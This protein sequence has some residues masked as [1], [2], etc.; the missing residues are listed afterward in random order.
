ME[1]SR[2]VRLYGV[3]LTALVGLMVLHAPLTVWLSTVAPSYTPLIKSWKELLMLPLAVFA[4]VLVSRAGLWRELARDWLVRLIVAYALLH[5]VVAAL[6]PRDTWAMLAGLAIDLRYVLLFVLIYIL[7]RLTPGWRRWLVYVTSAGAALVAVFA[8]VQ[9]LLPRDFL[10]HLGYS[11]ATIA[12]YLTVDENQDFVRFSS[13]LRGPNPLGAYMTIVLA[14][15]AA[16]LGYGKL[17]LR[18]R[19]VL[20]ATGLLVAA[21][22][23]ALWVSHSRSAWLGAVIAVVIVLSVA[24]RRLLTRRVFMVVG[25]LLVLGVGGLI[26]LRHTS[27]VST[28]FFHESPTTGAHISSNEGHVTSLEIGLM[29]T[30]TQPFGVGI[31]STGSA[32]L[33]GT[34]PG[35]II[36]ENQYLFVAHEAGWLG[37]ALFVMIYIILM[38]RLW[39]LRADWLGLGVFASGI[40]LAVVGLLLPVWVDDTVAL[41]WWALAAVVLGYNHDDR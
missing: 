30:L 28:V 5:L 23:V 17:A 14:S 16:L 19:A 31:G 37:L 40:G 6:L 27:F 35:G 22:L 3:G 21:S 8:V 1:H 20:L 18:R 13:T 25:A 41:V 4:V 15:V 10:T 29:Q 34:T 12:P 39:R 11:K 32:A 26:A 2:L 36:I 38:R 9:T 24:L 7:M 33:Y